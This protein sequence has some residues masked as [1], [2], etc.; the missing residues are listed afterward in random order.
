MLPCQILSLVEF[1]AL[2]VQLLLDV[3]DLYQL[4][5]PSPSFSQSGEDWEEQSSGTQQLSVSTPTSDV[6]YDTDE[7]EGK[8][9][10][11]LNQLPKP[12][13]NL[14]KSMKHGLCTPQNSLVSLPNSCSLPTRH[15]KEP[16]ES[17]KMVFPVPVTAWSDRH[18]GALISPDS[19]S[20]HA[21]W[22]AVP[23]FPPLESRSQNTLT[24]STISFGSVDTM[25][26]PSHS[27]S[28]NAANDQCET[29]R[30]PKTTGDKMDHK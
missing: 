6:N 8:T 7:E 30:R 5:A 10:F 15:P 14:H 18:P 19:Q 22:P 16:L 12:H 11:I 29:R 4:G 13:P 28:D 21:C 17:C 24:Q 1:T 9:P 3:F 20:Q 27:Y 26:T 25:V 2:A 23:S